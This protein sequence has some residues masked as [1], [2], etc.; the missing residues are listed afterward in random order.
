[1]K[2]KDNWSGGTWRGGTDSSCCGNRTQKSRLFC[3]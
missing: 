2:I 1:L 3:G